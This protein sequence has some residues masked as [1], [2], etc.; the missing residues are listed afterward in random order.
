MRITEMSKLTGASTDSLRYMEKKGFISSTLCNLKR[1]QV[2][3]YPDTEIR[4]VKLIMKYRQQGFTWDAAYNK[5][6]QELRSPLLFE[7][8]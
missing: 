3:D 7:D 5:T 6:S 1:R 2:R 8:L 4:K